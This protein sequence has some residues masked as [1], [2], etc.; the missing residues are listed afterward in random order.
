MQFSF[1]FVVIF[2][3]LTV[4][5][6]CGR[7]RRYKFSSNSLAVGEESSPVGG[8]VDVVTDDE[9]N[10]RRNSW[11][12]YYSQA[13]R[14]SNVFN[15]SSC[16]ICLR[17]YKETDKLRLLPDC[18]HLYHLHCVDPWLRLHPTCPL[19]RTSSSPSVVSNS[20]QNT[21]IVNVA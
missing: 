3:L 4:L 5:L 1:L 11:P 17:D 10:L 15:P 19:C 8:V 18:G 12:L 6:A 7:L 13:K 16:S 9:S 20:M 21:V 2:F 14:I